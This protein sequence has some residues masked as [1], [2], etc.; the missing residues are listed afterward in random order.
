MDVTTKKAAAIIATMID[1]K[2][3]EFETE[4]SSMKKELSARIDVMEKLLE[5]LSSKKTGKGFVTEEELRKGMDR[6]ADKTIIKVEDFEKDFESQ[7]KDVYELLGESRLK[8]EEMKQTFEAIKEKSATI[9]SFIKDFVK[10]TQEIF[11]L[12]KKIDK[13]TTVFRTEISTRVSSVEREVS[14]LNKN[15]PDNNRLNKK[16]SEFKEEI[17][18]DLEKNIMAFE[19]KREDLDKSLGTFDE[20]LKALENGLKNYAQATE[21]NKINSQI[22]KLSSIESS[23]K[24][25]DKQ[26]ERMEKRILKYDNTMKESLKSIDTYKA[27]MEEIRARLGKLEAVSSGVDFTA[28]ST[29]KMAEDIKNEIASLRGKMGIL[30]QYYRDPDRWVGDKIKS[31]FGQETTE[32]KNMVASTNSALMSQ[33]AEFLSMMATLSLTRLANSNDYNQIASE[34]R[35]LEQIL[36]SMRANNML[37]PET[38]DYV[39]EAISNTRDFWETRNGNIAALMQSILER[40]K[41]QT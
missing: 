37:R 41:S 8:L 33:R 3:A 15:T 25:M 2:V 20:K 18:E 21:L 1:K 6:I 40:I 4:L 36:S 22:S 10:R 32:L 26:A 31:W 16:L 35:V 14:N 19:K 28:K 17:S 38:M 9:D 13:D 30:E 27:A 11:D 12:G 29:S 34:S 24:D 39:E 5:E 23:K 7:K